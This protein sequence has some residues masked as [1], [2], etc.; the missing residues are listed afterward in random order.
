VIFVDTDIFL[1]AAGAESERR[2]PCQEVLARL[3]E[4]EPGL[5]SRTDAAVLGEALAHCRSHGVPEKGAALFDA[6]ASLGIPVLPVGEESM[7]HAR[8]LMASIPE[9]GPRAAVHA[10]VMRVHGIDRILSY[11]EDFDYVRGLERLEPWLEDEA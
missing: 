9:L 8:L 3:V 5:V 11:D 2:G 6:V 7:R 1:H 10:G 4:E